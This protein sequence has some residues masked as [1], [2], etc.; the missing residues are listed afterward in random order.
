MKIEKNIL[1]KT[2]TFISITFVRISILKNHLSSKRLLTALRKATFKVF[3]IQ[4]KY[5]KEEE[6]LAQ[7]AYC[8]YD[9]LKE[10]LA[11]IDPFLM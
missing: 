6:E 9:C 4:I 7:W 8:I 10:K 3:M 2:A 11:D 1:S 5:L